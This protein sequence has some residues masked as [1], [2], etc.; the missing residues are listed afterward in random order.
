MIAMILLLNTE[1][2]PRPNLSFV[3]QEILTTTANLYLKN[4]KIEVESALLP[5]WTK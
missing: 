2:L 3:K 4:V 5:Y 1:E